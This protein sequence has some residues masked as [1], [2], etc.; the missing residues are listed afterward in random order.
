LYE[1]AIKAYSDTLIL[2]G[3][4]HGSRFRADSLAGRAAALRDSALLQ[5]TSQKPD[6]LRRAEADYLEASK[7]YEQL[8]DALN[9]YARSLSDRGGTLR[10]L[11]AIDSSDKKAISLDESTQLQVQALRALGQKGS[12][13]LHSVIH[14]EL[15]NSKREQ[16]LLLGQSGDKENA[17]KTLAEAGGQVEKALQY[18]NPEVPPGMQQQAERLK[19]D[20]ERDRRTL[21]CPRSR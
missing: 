9:Q 10:Q 13:D 12:Y 7:V 19:R 2:L 8:P 14:W 1:E 17:C 6:M 15:A 3:D 21:G 20:I 16:A 5:D 18:S 4:L 11:A